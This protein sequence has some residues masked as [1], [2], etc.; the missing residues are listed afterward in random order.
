MVTAARLAIAAVAATVLVMAAVRPVAAQTAAPP[1]AD[2]TA[3]TS[4]VAPAIDTAGRFNDTPES[5]FPARVP[6]VAPPGMDLEKGDIEVFLDRTSY[7]P[8]ATARVAVG[9][10]IER[11]WHTNSHLPTYDNLIATEVSVDVPPG[12]GLPGEPEYPPGV[13]KTFSFAET[14]ISVYDGEV[15]IIGSVAVPTAAGPGTYPIR[16]TVTYQACD[17]LMCLAP[18]TTETTLGLD[19][20][21][22]GQPGEP[23]NEDLFAVGPIMRGEPGY[24]GAAS[25]GRSFI[26]FLLLAFLGGL[27]LNAMPCVLPVLSLK[28]MGLVKSAEGGRGSVVAGSLATA[29]GILVSFMLLA[30]AAVVARSAGAAVGWG[31]QFQ[32]PAFVAALTVIVLLFT[33]NLWGLFEIPLPAFLA[34]VGASGPSDGLAGHLTTGFFATLMA[35]PCSAPFLGTALGFALTQNTATTLAMFGA[36]GTGM[37]SPYLL[38][39]AAPGLARVLPRPGPWMTKFRVAM[40][41]LLAGTALWLL[42]VLSG[43]VSLDPFVGFIALLLAISAVTW[44]ASRTEAFSSRRRLLG[45]ATAVLCVASV[46]VAA[47]ASGGETARTLGVAPEDRLIA[48]QTFDRDLAE[49]AAAAGRYVFVDVTADWCLTCKVNEGLFLE[50]EE[51]AAAFERHDVLALRADWTRR[52]EAIGEYLASFDRYGIPFYVMYR[53]GHEPYVFSELLS[54]SAVIDLLDSD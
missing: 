11:G 13:M 31:I 39:A 23:T 6:Q 22:A 10:T 24:G 50:T 29:L 40:G 45:A 48:W 43:L 37:A 34:R 7:E 51:V 52:D 44:A 38:L 30:A 36:I 27:I 28:V 26:G 17:D 5:A 54:R 9:L 14:A 49:S 42:Y 32:N 18:V 46:V 33:L 41:F 15:T 16:I 3:G 19:V 20:V 2:T 8:G 53:P 1:Q 12:W 21:A 25:G 4:V 47:R 35:T